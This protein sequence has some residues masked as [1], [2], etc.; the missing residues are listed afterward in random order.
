MEPFLKT[1][2]IYLYTLTSYIFV[3]FIYIILVILIY[4]IFIKT[5]DKQIKL[6]FLSYFSKICCISNTVLFI[7]INKFLI[8]LL[9]CNND[10]NTDSINI[11]CYSTF[12]IINLTIISIALIFFYVLSLMISLL[13]YDKYLNS[14]CCDNRMS[15]SVNFFFLIAKILLILIFDIIS[16]YTSLLLTSLLFFLIIL[17]LYIKIKDKN[18]YYNNKINKIFYCFIFINYWSSLIV[19]INQYLLYYNIID[20]NGNIEIWLIGVISIIIY[21]VFL[22]KDLDNMLIYNAED[23]NSCD[24]AIKKLINFTELIDNINK[25]YD[26]KLLMNSYIINHLD[27]CSDITCPLLEYKNEYIL[28]DIKSDVEIQDVN[29]QTLTSMNKIQDKQ[30]VFKPKDESLKLLYSYINILYLKLI[31]KFNNN[32]SLKLSYCV[33]LSDRLKN[34]NIIKVQ[35]IELKNYKLT[36]AQQF[37]VYRLNRLIKKEFLYQEE[38][39]LNLHVS[40]I[41]LFN[42]TFKKFKLNL[43]SIGYMY[44]DFW[45]NFVQ[46]EVNIQKIKHIGYKINELIKDTYN[47]WNILQ[48]LNAKDNESCRLYGLFLINI[49]NEEKEGLKYLNK[50]KIVDKCSNYNSSNDNE[51]DSFNNINNIYKF[52]SLNNTIYS[53]TNEGS[54]CMIAHITDDHSIIVS[55]VT[56]SFVKFFG[57]SKEEI[58]NKSINVIVPYIFQC[59]HN[60][61]LKNYIKNAENVKSF[62]RKYI[63]SFAKHKTGFII[64]VNITLEYMPSLKN[65]ACFIVVFKRDLSKKHMIEGD[66]IINKDLDIIN[67][68]NECIEIF[69]FNTNIL[70][71][72]NENCSSNSDNKINLKNIIYEFLNSN[73]EYFNSLKISKRNYIEYIS[74]RMQICHLI[75]YEYL[76]NASSVQNKKSNFDNLNEVMLSNNK[77][78]NSNNKICNIINKN[79]NNKHTNTLKKVQM[80][81]KPILFKNKDTGYYNVKLILPLNIKNFLTDNNTNKNN[82][83]INPYIVSSN[84]FRFNIKKFSIV[85]N[86]Y[87]QNINNS[88]ILNGKINY[89]YSNSN[90]I[91]LEYIDKFYNKN[92]KTSDDKKSNNNKKKSKKNKKNKTTNKNKLDLETN[93]QIDMNVFYN[94]IGTDKIKDVLNKNK[95][96]YDVYSIDNYGKDVICYKIDINTKNIVYKQVNEIRKV[97]DLK[98]LTDHNDIINNNNNNNNDLE[99]NNYKLSCLTIKDNDDQNKVNL[100]CQVNKILIYSNNT[101]LLSRKSNSNKLRIT[102]LLIFSIHI[103]FSLTTYLIYKDNLNNFREAVNGI[104]YFK[105]QLNYTLSTT[106]TLLDI[107]IINDNRYQNIINTTET[108][109]IL[110]DNIQNTSSIIFETNRLISSLNTFDILNTNEIL[111]SKVKIST[112]NSTYNKLYDDNIEYEYV[113]LI[114]AIMKLTSTINSILNNLNS[115]KF[116][117]LDVQFYLHNILKSIYSKLN[118]VT[119]S[120]IDNYK[121]I[122][123]LT[124]KIVL[125][126]IVI[127]A[128]LILMSLFYYILTSTIEKIHIILLDFMSIKPKEALM[129]VKNTQNYIKNINETDDET[130]SQNEDKEFKK[131]DNNKRSAKSSKLSSKLSK[132]IKCFFI[133]ILSWFFIILISYYVIFLYLSFYYYQNTIIFVDLYNKINN[134]SNDLEIINIDTKLI[135][136]NNNNNINIKINNTLPEVSFIEKLDSLSFNIREF[137]THFSNKY[138]ISNEYKHIFNNELLSYNLTNSLIYNLNLKE[139]HL[140]IDVR[141][142]K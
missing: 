79:N 12:H 35:L 141:H 45:N 23:I 22:K 104:V 134:I 10:N 80:N 57:Y 1:T 39:Q 63:A 102:S 16:N 105:S 95:S 98:D 78:N 101:K 2:N 60:K 68:T 107:I 128:Y 91:L 94:S 83:A 48:I 96:F 34:L 17:T 4:I 132:K 27:K 70:S 133:L 8:T 14:N 72:L 40:S 46:E 122:D 86:S 11:A 49:L 84:V 125:L 124:D 20:F 9:F 116:D 64:S 74:D 111:D 90:K 43:I 13:Y 93:K 87:N 5:K 114:E 41:M 112:I 26:F 37:F 89:N 55:Q 19:L 97:G 69:N 106:D 103:A 71:L 54:P 82:K 42:E 135:V 30:N 109:N 51:N 75:D 130:N 59:E 137:Y 85:I 24:L 100:D 3:A 123:I 47:K 129:I 121:L 58:I 18:I 52:K 62:E 53:F 31:N 120:Y 127:I 29:N 113:L 73:N 38:D 28:K 65:N 32:C 118:K 77:G 88:N 44:I 15:N 136:I 110:K 36:I 33:F 7:P 61:I 67:I 25:R 76:Y 66:M 21:S 92:I 140:E 115:I 50:F 99:I 126:I 131:E 56:S 6:W 119:N 108:I 142:I 138:I 81:I 139:E 117:S